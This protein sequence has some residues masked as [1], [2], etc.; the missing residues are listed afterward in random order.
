MEPVLRLAILPALGAVVVGVGLL[1]YYPEG[2]SGF[3]SALV[4]TGLALFV[5]GALLAAIFG[6]VRFV[7]WSA[8]G[9]P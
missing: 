2:K 8:R 7:K 5:L 3:G 9:Q 6:L 1:I 4:L